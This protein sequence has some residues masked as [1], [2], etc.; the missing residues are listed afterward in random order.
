LLKL[1]IDQFL[2]S[3]AMNP[4]PLNIGINGFGRIGRLVMRI[5]A[6]H[7]R[8]RIVRINDP[9]GDAATLT[10]RASPSV[11]IKPS[12]TPTGRAAMS[13]SKLPAR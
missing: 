7:P 3:I 1:P 6:E 5:A 9:A 8:I 13:S 11:T 10:A 2:E 12:P 4:S